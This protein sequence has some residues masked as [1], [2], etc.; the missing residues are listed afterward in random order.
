MADTPATPGKD[1]VFPKPNLPDCWTPE[2]DKEV[3][4]D[5]P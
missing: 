3:K 4:E 5:G 1:V 2:P